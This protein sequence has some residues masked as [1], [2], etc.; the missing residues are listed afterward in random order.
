MTKTNLT[1]GIVENQ[2]TNQI[3][4]SI[5]EPIENILTIDTQERPN[6]IPYIENIKFIALEDITTVNEENLA[7]D[8]QISTSIKCHICQLLITEELKCLSCKQI[9]H[10]TCGQAP[11]GECSSSDIM[12]TFCWRENCIEKERD[13][14]HKNLKRAADYMSATSS[15]KEIEVGTTVLVDVPRYDR[16]PLDDKNITGRVVGKKQDLYRVGTA[17]GIIKDWLPRNAVQISPGAK[18]SDNV[19][20]VELPIRGIA[21]GLSPFGGQGF[22]Q[23]NCKKSNIQCKT[24]K[25]ACKKHGVLCNS[26][27]H[28]SSNCCNK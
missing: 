1:F 28:N 18:F 9:I 19:P 23:C 15:K 3:E 17:V 12:F 13:L 10:R 26:K 6:E 20:A 25:C 7:T 4:N 14:S 2:N 8:A 24:K 5:Q 22:K 11:I 21:S 27:C 16:A